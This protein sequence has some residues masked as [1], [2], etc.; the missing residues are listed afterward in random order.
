[1]F[2]AKEIRETEFERIVRGYNPDDVDGFLAQIADQIED[3]TAEKEAAEKK[4][5]EALERMD[6]Y[7]E[8]G[9][10]LRS[11]LVTAEKMKAQ[12]LAEAKET[13]EKLLAEATAHSEKLVADAQGKSDA[14]VGE[15]ANKVAIEEATLKTLKKQVSDFKNN[16]LN[17]YKQHLETLSELPEEGDD[18]VREYTAPAYEPSAAD[19]PSMPEMPSIEPLAEQTKPA[20]EEFAFPEFG[21]SKPAEAV[22]APSVEHAAADA[23]SFADDEQGNRFGKLDFGDSFTFGGE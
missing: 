16:V 20:D 9:D 13:S 18:D 14:I 6:T 23:F 1:M 15:I 21:A 4:A 12:M 2:T 22:E 11:V 7:R 8:D 3:L 5:K 17:I 10:A 19:I